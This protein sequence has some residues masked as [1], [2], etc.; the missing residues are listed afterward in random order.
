VTIADAAAEGAPGRARAVPDWLWLT[1]RLLLQ[2][3]VI[4]L[5][6]LA[7]QAYL[8][9]WSPDYLQ[10]RSLWHFWFT[11]MIVPMVMLGV[12]A[13]FARLLP[14]G[15]MLG[16]ALLFVGTLSAIKKE[17]TG[18]PFQISDLFLAG[19]SVHLLHYVH[20]HHWVLG[21]LIIP[22][23]I[24][25][26]LNLR[27]RWWSLPVA[28]ICVALLST[29]RIQ[30]VA[31]WIHDN[32]W[33]IGVENLT[34][35]QAESE[36]MNGLATHLYFSTA[37]LRLKT[38]TQAEVKQAIDALHAPKPAAV[39]AAG[40]APD[41]YIILG[42]AWWRDPNDSS[43]PLDQLKGE[44]FA[45]STAVS[46][47]YGGTTPNAEFEAL[48]GIPVKTFQDGIIPY[49]H[50]V[51][52]ITEGA[53]TLPRILTEKG[54]AAAAYHNFTRRFWLRDQI[55]PK[56]GFGEFVSMDQM[57]L[58]IQ[59]NDWPT[60][61]GLYKSVLDRVGGDKPQFHFI[62]TV[63]THGPYEADDRDRKGH[64]GVTDYRTRLDAAVRA[65]TAFKAELD[66]KGRPYALV[67]FGDHLPGLRMHQFHDGMKSESDPRLHQIPVLI[68]SNTDSPQALADA[69]RGRPLYCLS[70]LV[71][72]WI[73]RPVAESYMSYL[74]AS[75][76]SSEDP[77][78]RPTE[79]VIQNQLFT[80]NP[81]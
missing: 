4:Y 76:R 15:A 79:A 14:A 73:G 57:T 36:R 35:S 3:A 51:Q 5:G 34:F 47:V 21:A 70:P 11:R 25:Y 24:W 50:Y 26:V 59:P 78:L 64:E 32:S 56:L 27:F 66:A 9:W 68:A 19:Q 22:A 33:W 75:C 65:L 72:D 63:Q 53:R 40:P 20:W 8:G 49:Q 58:T 69:I 45:E 17:S 44:G 54:Y 43:S 10:G 38:F 30:W 29:Y 7:I 12:L 46:P 1:G 67:L 71:L 80:F 81:L 23:A 74:N 60:D 18:E 55:Y 39:A 61:D 62:V 31:N 16:A 6:L 37:G 2:L 77:K 48:T 52:Y 41:V 28:L 42:E 13:S